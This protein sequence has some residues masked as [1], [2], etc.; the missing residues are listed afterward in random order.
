[1]LLPDTFSAHSVLVLRLTRPASSRVPFGPRP[2][3]AKR[4][5]SHAPACSMRTCV[6]SR[7]SPR[8]Y[9]LAPTAVRPPSLCS[10]PRQSRSSLPVAC[11]AAV[12]ASP[13]P[14]PTSTSLAAVVDS[15]KLLKAGP[16]AAA[17]SLPLTSS[18][19][20]QCSREVRV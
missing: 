18:S 16:A 7:L 19:R 17:P 20:S 14:S 12:A 9:R 6:G 4:A 13:S 8:R 1:M 10:P 2:W 3:L 15:I 11:P 5:S